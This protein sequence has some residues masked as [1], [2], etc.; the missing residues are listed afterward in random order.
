VAL[1]SRAPEHPLQPPFPLAT[2]TNSRAFGHLVMPLLLSVTM[3]DSWGSCSNAATATSL[4]LA[5]RGGRGARVCVWGG[6]GRGGYAYLHSML[7]PHASLH[8]PR[9]RSSATQLSPRR[10][11][12]GATRWILTACTQT[13]PHRLPHSLLGW[14]C[15]RQ[16]AASAAALTG[17]PPRTSPWR[18]RRRSP[19]VAPGGGGVCE[20][21]RC[22]SAQAR[23]QPSLTCGWCW[24]SSPAP[25]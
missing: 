20:C 16:C 14:S 12:C 18:A 17:L 1:T 4:G 3:A 10:A 9:Q 2:P 8:R 6:G 19:C 22:A 7:P 25:P 13:S 11:K 5:C 23:L 21:A 15:S 24:G